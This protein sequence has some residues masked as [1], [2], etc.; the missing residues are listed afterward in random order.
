MMIPEKYILAFFMVLIQFFGTAQNHGLLTSD[1]SEKSNRLQGKLRGEIF[2]LNPL[3]NAN[4]FLQKEWENGTII[5]KDGDV[6]ENMR[7]RYMAFGDELVAYNNNTRSL[8]VVDKNTVGGFIFYSPSEIANLAGQEFVNLDSLNPPPFKSYFQKLYWGRGK[9]LC[10]YQI[11]INKVSPYT[12]ADGK[13]YDAEYRLRNLYYILT[14]NND[15]F[16]IQLKNRSL[17]TLFPENKR[18]IKKLFRKNRI[19]ISNENSAIQAVKLLDAE[20]FL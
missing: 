15:F 3:S 13:M 20:G 7:M 19:N 18:A 17:Y 6:F 14:E 10:F 11:E 8:F 16:K 9:L 5:L 12:G 1:L 4:Y 2:Y